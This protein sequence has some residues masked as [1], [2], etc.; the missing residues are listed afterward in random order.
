MPLTM[1]AIVSP[2]ARAMTARPGQPPPAQHE[3]S[4]RCGDREGVR[5]DR[6]RADDQRVA[7][8]DHP[9]RGHYTRGQHEHEIA[10]EW[11]SVGAGLAEQVGPHDAGQGAVG[12]RRADRVEAH[13]DDVV[14]RDSKRVD[15]A[16]RPVDGVID[17]VRA[18]DHR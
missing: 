17:E 2:Q 12:L 14:R 3:G 5:T 16:K 6:H 8:V 9:E 11:P 4:R 10:S 7:R 1:H 18:D 13:Q 15:L